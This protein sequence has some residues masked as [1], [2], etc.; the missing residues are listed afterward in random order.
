[1]MRENE[2]IGPNAMHK[3]DDAD[4]CLDT[5]IWSGCCLFCL[6]RWSIQPPMIQQRKDIPVDN[7]QSHNGASLR[8]VAMVGALVDKIQI[9]QSTVNCLTNPKELKLTITKTHTSLSL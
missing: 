2:L 1:M 6:S 9:E 3:Y 7:S 8:D 4:K 5:V